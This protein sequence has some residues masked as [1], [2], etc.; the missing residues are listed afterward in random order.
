MVQEKEQ[1]KTKRKDNN[2]D[3]GD[4]NKN[5]KIGQPYA[6][7]YGKEHSDVSREKAIAFSGHKESGGGHLLYYFCR[8]LWYSTTNTNKFGTNR[9][10]KGS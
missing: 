10:Q 5:S 6:I 7:L 8:L 1:D 2:K 4:N 9:A 3:D